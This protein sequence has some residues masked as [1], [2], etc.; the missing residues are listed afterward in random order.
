MRW[1]SPTKPAFTSHYLIGEILKDVGNLN[2]ARKIRINTF[3][4]E[5]TGI[6]P[7]KIPGQPSGPR[8]TPTPQDVETFVDFM[9]RLAEDNHGS[10][11]PI[12]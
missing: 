2:A 4:F 1:P 12:K 11:R 10:F 3:G 9:K 7:D 5:G 8:P 6:W